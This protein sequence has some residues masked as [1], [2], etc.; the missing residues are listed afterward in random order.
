MDMTLWILQILGVGL[1]LKPI[2]VL[3]YAAILGASQDPNKFLILNSLATH[4][5]LRQSEQ[6]LDQN[7]KITANL[8]IHYRDRSSHETKRTISLISFNTKKDQIIAYCNMTGSPR[9]FS[10]SNILNAKDLEDGRPI[11]DVREF[12]MARACK[13]ESKFYQ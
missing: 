4:R 7:I 8:K 3:E 12:L 9:T 2:I 5:R 10:I 6:N 13:L 11:K 1:I